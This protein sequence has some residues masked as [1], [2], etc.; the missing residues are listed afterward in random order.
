MR[1]LLCPESGRRP[2]LL[3]G[4]YESILKLPPLVLPENDVSFFNVYNPLSGEVSVAGDLTVIRDIITALN[5][6]IVIGYT[7]LVYYC[8]FLI[9]L[10]PF[11]LRVMIKIQKRSRELRWRSQLTFSRFCLPFPMV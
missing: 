6:S 2:H 5:E 11:K 1:K 10:F 9:C 7:N 8:V 3:Y 4:S